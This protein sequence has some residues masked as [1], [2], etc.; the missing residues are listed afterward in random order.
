MIRLSLGTVEDIKD[1]SRTLENSRLFDEYFKHDKE[2]SKFFLEGIA[3][4]ELYVAKDVN[5][6]IIGCMRVDEKGMLSRFPLLRLIAVKREYRG[7]GFGTEMLRFYESKYK[8]K[9]SRIFLCV[10]SFNDKAKKLYF[11][12]GFE[13]IGKINGLY[14]KG[15]TEYILMKEL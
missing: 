8:G 3:K 2:S 1:C 5:A 15:I 11:S 6:N 13:E 4:E 10:S 7:K 12:L 14:K 9:T